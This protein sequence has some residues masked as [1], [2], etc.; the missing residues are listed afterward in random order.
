M[1]VESAEHAT[2][3]PVATKVR[4]DAEHSSRS[5]VEKAAVEENWLSTS[6]LHCLKIK[7]RGLSALPSSDQGY[8]Q[9]AH[10]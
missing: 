7:K 8:P 6:L 1:M 3:W 10:A 5:A 2:R 4:V 9:R